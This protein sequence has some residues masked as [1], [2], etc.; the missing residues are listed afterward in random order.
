MTD[1]KSLILGKEK[2]AG[3]TAAEEESTLRRTTA[4]RFHSTHIDRCLYRNARERLGRHAAELRRG[5]VRKGGARRP[6]P[7][8]VAA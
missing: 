7:S 1:R 5:D 4:S 2:A 8:E 6:S 3:R